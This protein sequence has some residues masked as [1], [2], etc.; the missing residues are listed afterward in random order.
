[1]HKQLRILGLVEA[2]ARAIVHADL[3][4]EV[5]AAARAIVHADLAPEHPLQIQLLFSRTTLCIPLNFV[6]HRFRKSMTLRFSF[7][8]RSTVSA[9]S[10][11]KVCARQNELINSPPCAGEERV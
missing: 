11:E 4:P 9:V 2:A 7:F 1:M 5:E 8:M 6:L 10:F 3:A